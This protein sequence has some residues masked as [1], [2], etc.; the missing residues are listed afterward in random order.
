MASVAGNHR[1]DL[2]E[3]EPLPANFAFEPDGRWEWRSFDFQ[4][5]IWHDAVRDAVRIATHTLTAETC[6]LAGQSSSSVKLRDGR[7][8]VKRLSRTGEYGMEL[9]RPERARE[10]PLAARAVAGLFDEWKRPLRASCRGFLAPEDLI[11]YVAQRV[12]HVR[13]VPVRKWRRVYRTSGCDVEWASALISG[14]LLESLSLASGDARTLR[15]TLRA[16][17]VDRSAAVRSNAAEFMR[18][19]GLLR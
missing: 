16:L 13:I 2:R 1:I 11:S 10:F 7:L 15:D 18:I 6:F 12:P 17:H 5:Q 3:T 8:D 4:P 9:R 19:V 14:Q